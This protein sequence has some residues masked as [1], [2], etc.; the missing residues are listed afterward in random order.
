MGDKVLCGHAIHAGAEQPHETPQLGR[1]NSYGLAVGSAHR[2]VQLKGM[3]AKVVDSKSRAEE[4]PF[5]TS[6]G[7]F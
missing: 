6:Q 2:L 1:I 7:P 5:H 4:L 3:H